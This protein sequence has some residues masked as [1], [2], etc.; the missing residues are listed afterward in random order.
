LFA[1][2]IVASV[3]AAGLLA[4]LWQSRRVHRSMRTFDVTPERHDEES[5]SR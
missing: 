3:L 1:F 5:R 4:F 2:V